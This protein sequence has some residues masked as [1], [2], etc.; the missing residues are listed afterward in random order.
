MEEKNKIDGIIEE[1][2]LKHG[3]SASRVRGNSMLPLLRHER[4][5]VFLKKCDT[6]PRKYDIVLYRNEDGRYILHR[7]IGV[8]GDFLVIRGDNT[9][10]REYV[11]KG[12]ILAVLVSYTR[13]GKHKS[14]YSTAHKVYSVVWCLIYPIR[15]CLIAARRVLGRVYRFIFKKK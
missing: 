13:K 10:E 2:L 9:Y 8:K 14:V 5:A 3:S 15:R 12:D 11:S 6:S 7:V 4:D 1:E